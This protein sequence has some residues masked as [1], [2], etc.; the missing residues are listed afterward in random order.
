M[1]QHECKFPELSEL[2]VSYVKLIKAMQL[3]RE[4]QVASVYIAL[5][6]R[7]EGGTAR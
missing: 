1:K 3:M 5:D 6:K 7:R 2:L 4:C